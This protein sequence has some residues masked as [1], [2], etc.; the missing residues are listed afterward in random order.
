MRYGL[1]E[2]AKRYDRAGLGYQEAVTAYHRALNDVI[3]H[4]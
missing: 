1:F 3:A 2:E 4:E